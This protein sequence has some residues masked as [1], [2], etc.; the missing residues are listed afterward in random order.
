MPITTAVFAPNILQQQQETQKE[1]NCSEQDFYFGKLGYSNMQRPSAQSHLSS[2]LDRSTSSYSQKRPPQ[3]PKY[4]HRC[5][6]HNNHD[7]HHYNNKDYRYKDQG[8]QQYNHCNRTN[9]HR[10]QQQ[11]QEIN[12]ESCPA[13]CTVEME[14]IALDYLQYVIQC[15]SKNIGQFDRI[16]P[17]FSSMFVGMKNNMFVLS[18][19][20]E[21]IFNESVKN[22]NF[23][24]IGAKLSCLLYKLNPQKDSLFY[25]LLKYQLDFYQN[26]IKEYIKTNQ[27]SKMR[28]TTLFLAELYIQLRGE[29]FHTQFI[30]ES[31]LYSLK[32]LL[33]ENFDNVR[34]VCLTLK[35]AGY[36]L[37]ADFSK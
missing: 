28:E 37:T 20:M 32:R 33:T 26:E 1:N 12:S 11:P 3:E 9:Y 30:A 19:A 10:Q 34:C 8:C 23:R 35:L 13:N 5:S 7:E 4:S 18:N 22:A 2:T 21:E 16:S 17:R 27:E 31:I 15:L 14:N 24:Y 29:E 25:T 6:N 36:D